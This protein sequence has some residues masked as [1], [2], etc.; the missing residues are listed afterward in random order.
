M[1]AS[2]QWG[3]SFAF[4]P[5]QHLLLFTT[6]PL[7]PAHPELPHLKAWDHQMPTFYLQF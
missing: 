2:Q 7:S 5:N 1:G 6:D 3:D 4:T